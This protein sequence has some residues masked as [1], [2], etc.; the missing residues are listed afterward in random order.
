MR[1]AV[2]A[3]LQTKK[4]V[5]T[6]SVLTACCFR[7]PRVGLEPT[8]PPV[9]GLTATLILQEPSNSSFFDAA[10]Q[11]YGVGSGFDLPGPEQFPRP[12][13]ALGG[14]GQVVGRIVVLFESGLQ[15]VGLAAIEAAGRLALEDIDPSCHK[16]A[17]P[18]LP[19]GR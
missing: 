18:G 5:R 2:L 19:A 9:A 11:A 3:A 17:L 1:D 8:I 4:A 7:A 14:F 15:M 12:F 16:E 10:L 6:S 13:A